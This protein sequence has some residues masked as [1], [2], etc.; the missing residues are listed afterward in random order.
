MCFFPAVSIPVINK[1]PPF[2]SPVP[3]RAAV[4]ATLPHHPN[5]STSSLSPAS[6]STVSRGGSTKLGGFFKKSKRVREIYMCLSSSL[7]LSTVSKIHNPF[8][9]I[10]ETDK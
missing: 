8:Q 4:S 6:T 1:P 10:S 3:Q 2:S 7:T 9:N 5:S